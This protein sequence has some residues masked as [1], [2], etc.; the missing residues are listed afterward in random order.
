MANPLADEARA[1]TEEQL[2]DAINEAYR[3]VF[4]L[5]FQKGTRQLNNPMA[6]RKA[7]RQLARLRTIRHERILAGLRGLELTPVEAPAARELS[8]QKKRAQ[9]ERAAA[10]QEAAAV[11]AEAAPAADA[12]T[13]PTDDVTED[14]TEDVTAAPATPA[15]TAAA[16]SPEDA[17]EPD[18]EDED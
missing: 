1:L 3:E 8:P 5:H 14:M 15:E 12:E 11:Q 13:V 10:E 7:R 6:I 4:N 17:T 2:A 18:A 16:A 9:E